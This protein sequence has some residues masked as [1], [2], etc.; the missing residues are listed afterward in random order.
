MD[1][2]AQLMKQNVT[3]PFALLIFCVFAWFLL[4]YQTLWA[5]IILGNLIGMFN[6]ALTAIKVKQFIDNALK[7]KRTYRLGMLTRFSM[8]ALGVFVALQFPHI[9]SLPGYAIGL[10]LPTVSVVGGAIYTSIFSKDKETISRER[11]EK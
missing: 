6:Q 8:G 2:Y 10:L 9:F 7:E 4:P 1:T 5:G 11:G 3:F